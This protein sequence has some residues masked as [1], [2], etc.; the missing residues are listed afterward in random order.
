LHK[1]TAR[2]AWHT[3]KKWQARREGACHFFY[4]NLLAVQEELTDRSKSPVEAV[5]CLQAVN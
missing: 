3:N 5:F 4:E 2:H 1:S